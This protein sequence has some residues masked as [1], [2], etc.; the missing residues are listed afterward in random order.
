[1][2]KKGVQLRDKDGVQKL[3][4]VALLEHPYEAINFSELGESH[5]GIILEKQLHFLPN[6]SCNYLDL[7][8]LSLIPWPIKQLTFENGESLKVVDNNVNT[9]TQDEESLHELLVQE[10]F[11][12][13]CHEVEDTNGIGYSSSDNE[14]QATV[15]QG[16]CSTKR[17]YVKKF[18]IAKTNQ[19]PT[20]SKVCTIGDVQNGCNDRL[21][22]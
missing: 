10:D 15:T 6:A 16:S 19:N 13:S 3:G 9:C 18:R 2:E 7:P 12:A 5:L 1:M 22:Q 17:R 11:D 14:L 4:G 21:L 8:H 20:Y